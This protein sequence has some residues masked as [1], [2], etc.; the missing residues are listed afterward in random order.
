MRLAC[1]SLFISSALTL[2]ASSAFAQS[3]SAPIAPHDDSHLDLASLKVLRDRGTITDAEY[4][5]AVRDLNDTTGA[6]IAGD[7]PTFVIGKFSTT[8]YGQI[9]GD[10]IG[11]TTQ[12][13]TDLAGNSL[14][15]R[16][17]GSALAPPPAVQSAY[18]ATHPSGQ[19]SIH[20]SRLGFYFRAP[21]SQSHVRTSAL[22][23][24]DLFGQIASNATEQQ[25][26]DSSVPRVRHAYFRVETPVVDVLVGQY[27]HLFGWQNVYH[28]ASVMAQGLPGELYSRDIQLRLSKK[29]ET[30]PVTVELAVAALRPPARDSAIPQ[31]EAGLHIALN[32]WTGVMT[33]GSSGTALQP[34]SVAVTGNFREI[35]LPELSTAPTG[36][37]N[38][39]M[40][41]IAI[42]GFIPIIPATKD[43]RDNALAV[44]GEFVSGNGT[45]D[46]Y[47]GLTGGL[48]FPSVPNTSAGTAEVQGAT[49]PVQIDNGIVDF[50]AQGHLHAIS[51]VSYLFGLQYYLPF[52]NGRAFLVGNYS[53]MKSP[54]IAA[55][56]QTAVANPQVLSFTQSLAVIE[57]TDWVD[58]DLFLDVTRG[59]RVG[60]EVAHY[61]QHYVDGVLAQDTRVQGAGIFVF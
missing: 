28:P 58:G 30:R 51:W 16:P 47:T 26:Y 31:G 32:Q 44:H 20:D 41:S 10:F 39:G 61:W 5:A 9:K 49:Y 4:D 42:D 22:L 25:F 13:F 57:R 43:H 45:A 11:D 7:A 46:L 36:A 23:E 37:V 3:S 34:L 40:Q 60:A 59:V 38:K 52:T 12:G 35:S 55:Y 18:A 48:T 50:D 54:N 29:I 17:P 24:M 27:W 2:V 53:H 6:A 19:F 15:A 21:E 14:I 1:P 8:I 56:T 33:N